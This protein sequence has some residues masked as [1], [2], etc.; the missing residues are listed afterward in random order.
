MIEGTVKS[1]NS[2]NGFGF[3][4]TKTDGDV[5]VHYTAIL[6]TGFKSLEVGDHVQFVIAEGENG[7]QAAKVTRV[8]D[9]ERPSAATED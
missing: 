3:I 6:S 7:P 8:E 1:Y 2:K 9:P 4:K 5:F